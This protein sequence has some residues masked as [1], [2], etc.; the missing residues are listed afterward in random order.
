[1]NIR[2]KGPLRGGLENPKRVGP[3]A[4]DEKTEGGRVMLRKGAFLLVCAAGLVML[5]WSGI[6][7][8][9]S[10]DDMPPPR[11]VQELKVVTILSPPPPPPPPPKPVEQKMIEQTPVKQEIREE[12]PVE[13]PQ[14]APKPKDLPKDEPPPGPLALDSK[15]EGPGDSF[16]LG[17]KPGGRGI[18]GGGGGGGGGSSRF[19]WYAS[20]VQQQVAAALR[21]NPKTRSAVMQLQVRLWADG[22]GRINRVQLV[23]SSGNAE[24]DNAIR[25]EVL[26]G[27]TLREPPPKDMP[28]PIVARISARRPT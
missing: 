26:T 7:L 9:G 23:S 22:S 4:A 12:V 28:M 14:D 13:K 8:L 17:G 19:G 11:K 6:W 1:M 5:V 24:I 18:L 25:N 15:A 20:I 3:I 21:A 2:R 10:R 27:I 16:N